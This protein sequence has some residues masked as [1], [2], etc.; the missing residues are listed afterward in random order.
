[1]AFVAVI[2]LLAVITKIWFGRITRSWSARYVLIIR[3]FPQA[4]RPMPISLKG[5]GRFM[6]RRS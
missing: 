6:R 1:M 4:P 2:I 3:G 5:T